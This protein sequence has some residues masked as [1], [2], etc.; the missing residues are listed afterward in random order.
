LG[1]GIEYV[2]G[3]LIDQIK[4]RG[5]ARKRGEGTRRKES[6]GHRRKRQIEEIRRN[7]G[8]QEVKSKLF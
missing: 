2:S 6:G 7:S 4:E 8:G 1:E 5:K 3:I